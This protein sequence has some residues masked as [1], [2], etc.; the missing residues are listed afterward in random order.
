M[1]VRTDLHR[2]SAIVPEDYSFVSC[3]YYGNGLDAMAF[4]G[5]RMAFRAH[6][7]RTGGRYSGHEHGGTCGVCGAAAMY[8]AKYHHRPTNTY[9]VTGMDCAEK[10]DIADAV[11]FRSFKKRIAAGRKT[12]R[13]LAKAESILADAGLSAAWTIFR[14]TERVSFRKAEDIVTDIVGKL[15]RYGSISDPQ[16][17]LIRK[18]LGDIAQ[19]PARDAEFAAKRAEQV[20]TSRWVGT[21]GQRMQFDLTVGRIYRGEG[22]FGPYVILNCQDQAGNVVV[23]KGGSDLGLKVGDR[24]TV[25]ATVKGHDEWQGIA[26]TTVSRPKVGTARPAAEASQEAPQAS[27]EPV[28][29]VALAAAFPKVS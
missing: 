2:P 20:A 19:R 28:S 15:V 8:V 12:Y 17:G 9:I 5:D 24:A 10:M 3:D 18:L 4:M 11:A 22:N 21:V 26:Q 14:S 7:E 29:L 16:M 13:G 1:T 25:T 6:M 23:Y 27:Q